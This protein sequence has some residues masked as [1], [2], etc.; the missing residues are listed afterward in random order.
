MTAGSGHDCGLTRGICEM[1]LETRDPASL[2]SFPARPSVL[3]RL[4]D[5][6]PSP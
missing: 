4:R 2:A 1:T 5:S 6:T 3:G